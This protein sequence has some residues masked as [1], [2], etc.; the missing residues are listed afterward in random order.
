LNDDAKAPTEDLLG[1][2]QSESEYAP[3][4]EN[5][6]GQQFRLARLAIN[7]RGYH[8]RTQ[9]QRKYADEDYGRFRLSS[10]GPSQDQ[11]Q[12]R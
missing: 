5:A 12:K 7:Q 1:R 6:G 11:R 9:R 10:G 3:G 4:Y 2:H 8:F